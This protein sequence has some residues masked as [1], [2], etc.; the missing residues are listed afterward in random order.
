MIIKLDPG[1]YNFSR[2]AKFRGWDFIHPRNEF[3]PVSRN[4]FTNS[5]LAIFGKAGYKSGI[6][7]YDKLH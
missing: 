1:I 6:N 4:G 2:D 7:G 3:S 5:D